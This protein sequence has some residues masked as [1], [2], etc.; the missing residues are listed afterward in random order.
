MLFYIKDPSSKSQ[1]ERLL[2]FIKNSTEICIDMLPRGSNGRMVLVNR[3]SVDGSF[4]QQEKTL[5]RAMNTDDS[6]KDLLMMSLVQSLCLVG[7]GMILL[8]D[9]FTFGRRAI[10][11]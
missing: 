4:D 6:N 5:N 9:Q 8:M 7:T 11:L 1:A 10:L 3:A 2:M